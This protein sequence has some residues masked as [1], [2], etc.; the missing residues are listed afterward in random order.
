[1]RNLYN[2]TAAEANRIIDEKINA[3]IE[4][5]S[6]DLN[7]LIDTNSLN[8]WFI[9]HQPINIRTEEEFKLA[10]SHVDGTTIQ[11]KLQWL[12]FKSY[13]NDGRLLFRKAD[14]ETC[15][16]YINFT[17]NISS[18]TLTKGNPSFK[19]NGFDRLRFVWIQQFYLSEEIMFNP[20]ISII[21]SADG[22][23]Y[24]NQSITAFISP[25]QPNSQIGM[26]NRFCYEFD[27]L[28]VRLVFHNEER[29]PELTLT[30][31]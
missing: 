18:R 6:K 25:M 22:V 2:L 16:V 30:F 1:M 5:E 7:S 23:E 24:I 4:I 20:S 21:I 29:N 8:G 15:Q 17:P 11:G 19:F 12:Y 27:E 10:L 31:T 14:E 28:E 3:I 9:E 26:I 13:M